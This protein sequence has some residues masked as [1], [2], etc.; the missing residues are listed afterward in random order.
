M[1]NGVT[2]DVYEG[3]R[4]AKKFEKIRGERRGKKEVEEEKKEEK[5][6]GE[7]FSRLWWEWSLSF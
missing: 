5:E 3:E 4:Q 2:S 6:N 7:R 1:K